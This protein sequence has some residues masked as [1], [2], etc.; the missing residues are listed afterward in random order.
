MRLRTLCPDAVRLTQ[1]IRGSSGAVRHGIDAHDYTMALTIA[2]RTPASSYSMAT[3]CAL[4]IRSPIAQVTD[5]PATR[6]IQ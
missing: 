4:D 6:R 2:A 3:S 1:Q 5:Q